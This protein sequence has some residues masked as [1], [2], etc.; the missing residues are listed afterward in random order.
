MASLLEQ[1]SDNSRLVKPHRGLLILGLGLVGALLGFLG[2]LP[3]AIEQ[4]VWYAEMSNFDLA[5][6]RLIGCTGIFSGAMG[7]PAWILGQ[8]DKREMDDGTMDAGGRAV[9]QVGRFFGMMATICFAIWLV[10]TL[11]TMS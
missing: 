10:A 2:L 7:I 5:I 1:T 9:T 3:R 11:V 6:A 8:M 4:S